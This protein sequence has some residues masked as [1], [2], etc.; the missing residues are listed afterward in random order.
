[1]LFILLPV[2][3]WLLSLA[4]QYIAVETRHSVNYLACD[5]LVQLPV[6][7]LDF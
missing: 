3:A 4:V 7:A 2:A 5:T 6:R 1:M